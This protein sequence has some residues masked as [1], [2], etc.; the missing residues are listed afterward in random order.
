MTFSLGKPAAKTA[1]VT[2]VFGG[3]DASDGEEQQDHIN[4]RQRL[5]SSGCLKSP[6]DLSSIFSAALEAFVTQS[7]ALRQGGQAALHPAY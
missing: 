5:D 4:K 1:P 3:G 7:G 2:A 6:D